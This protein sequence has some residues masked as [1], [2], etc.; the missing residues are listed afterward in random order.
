MFRN[1]NINDYESYKKLTNSDL[2]YDKYNYFIENVLNDNHI[3]ILLFENNNIIGTGT[4]LIEE[5]LT[6]G[7]YKCGHIENVLINKKYRG[8]KYGQKL[9][10]YLVDLAKKKKCYRVV[11]ICKKEL[12]KFYTK[13]NFHSDNICMSLLL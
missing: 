13:N 10:H 1:I 11:L 4:L 3:M 7:G 2:S 5:K 8:N 12:E 9:I 6:N